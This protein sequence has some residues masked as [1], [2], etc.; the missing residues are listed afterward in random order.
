MA[1]RMLAVLRD[2]LLCQFDGSE[3]HWIVAQVYIFLVT[4]QPAEDY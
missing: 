2:A 1:S 3:W 4:K